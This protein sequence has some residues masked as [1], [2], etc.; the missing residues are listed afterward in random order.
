M[1]H[2]RQDWFP[3]LQNPGKHDQWTAAGGMSLGNRAIQRLRQIVYEHRPEP[4]EAGLAAELD[5]MEE[6]WWREASS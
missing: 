1:R 5:R 2:F 3:S 4:L 6:H